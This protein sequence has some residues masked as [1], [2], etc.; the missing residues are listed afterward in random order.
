MHDV[1]DTGLLCIL[2]TTVPHSLI[3]DARAGSVGDQPGDR[4]VVFGNIQ[5]TAVTAILPDVPPSPFRADGG[6]HHARALGWWG[7]EGLERTYVG[8]QV[9]R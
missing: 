4:S 7:V 2:R 1:L 5:Q 6:Y 8:V 3:P 9:R